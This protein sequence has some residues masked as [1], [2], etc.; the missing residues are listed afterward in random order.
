MV[1]LSC[2]FSVNISVYTVHYNDNVYT[3]EVS[4]NGFT[5]NGHER[6]WDVKILCKSRNTFIT[7]QEEQDV[8]DYFMKNREE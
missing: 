5:N 2:R 6:A 1:N 7:G 4:E 3:V 8:F